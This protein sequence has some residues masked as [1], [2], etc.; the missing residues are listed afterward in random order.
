MWTRRK[1]LRAIFLMML[2]GASLSG[3][4]PKDIEDLLHIM[5]KAKVEFTLPDEDA[6]GDSG[7][8]DYRSWI[9]F[10]DTESVTPRRTSQ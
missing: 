4:N 8:D 6:G 1:W 7:P 5:N 2:A 3:V 10:A 9:E